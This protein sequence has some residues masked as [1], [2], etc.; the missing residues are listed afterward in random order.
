[1]GVSNDFTP[2]SP[3]LELWFFFHLAC[4]VELTSKLVV[5]NCV[6]PHFLSMQRATWVSKMSAA[7]SAPD[8]SP[9]VTVLIERSMEATRTKFEC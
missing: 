6:F 1:M 5:G 3:D 7:P 4:L 9:I 8:N 2:I